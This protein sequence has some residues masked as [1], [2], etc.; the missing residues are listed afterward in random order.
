MTINYDEKGKIFTDVVHKK[1]VKAKIQTVSHY[2]EGEV[3]IRPDNRLKDELDL[4]EPFLAVTNACIF[5]SN[6]K[7]FFRTKFIGIRRE[8]IIW[9]TTMDDIINEGER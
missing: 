7:L 5:K 4:D 1:A 8:Q 9:V 3:Y 6:H 2:I